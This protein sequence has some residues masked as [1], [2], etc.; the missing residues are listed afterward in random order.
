METLLEYWEPA[1]AVLGALLLIWVTVARKTKSTKDDKYAEEALRTYRSLLGRVEDNLPA[2]P[3]PQPK[4]EAPAERTLD[5]GAV[6]KV[7]LKDGD[8]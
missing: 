2:R 3:A 8:R 1:V 5:Q 6:Q 7:R 4:P